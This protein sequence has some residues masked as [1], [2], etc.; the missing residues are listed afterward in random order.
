MINNDIS[1]GHYEIRYKDSL[2]E[3]SPPSAGSS[4]LSDGWKR[5]IDSAVY[6]IWMTQCFV[7]IGNTYGTWTKAVK[8]SSKDGNNGS[9]I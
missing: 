1:A 3:P 5:S 6:D 2:S 4:G 9:F 7:T 8:I